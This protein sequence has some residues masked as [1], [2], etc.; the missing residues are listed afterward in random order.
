VDGPAALSP[1][2]LAHLGWVRLRVIGGHGRI[3][4]GHG[5]TTYVDVRPPGAI[6]GRDAIADVRICSDEERV[7]RRHALL[8]PIGRFWVLS[9]LGSTHGTTVSADDGR[10]IEIPSDVP[11]PILGGERITLA[12]ALT[13]RAEIHGRPRPG[14]APTSPSGQS[15]AERPQRLLNPDHQRLADALTKGRREDP[16]SEFYPT[17]EELASTLNCSRRTVYN[18]LEQLSAVTVVSR[19]LPEGT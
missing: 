7:S 11:F 19:H 17:A 1:G 15:P 9:D 8:Q 12:D 18:W 10:V 6:I 2:M 5:T 13:M 3:V 14:V 16:R 4:K